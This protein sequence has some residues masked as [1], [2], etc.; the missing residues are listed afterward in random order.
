[1][2]SVPGTRDTKLSKDSVPK[3]NY[4]HIGIPSPKHNIRLLKDA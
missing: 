1:M 2:F 4:N 3:Y